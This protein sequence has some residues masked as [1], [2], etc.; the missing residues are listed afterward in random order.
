MCLSVAPVGSPCQ[1]NRDGEISPG[2]RCTTPERQGNITPTDQCEGPPN[3][4]ELADHT[5]FGLNVNG[6]VCLNNTCMY[7]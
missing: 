2:F 3:H 6:S 1:F 4:K 5:G 7:A